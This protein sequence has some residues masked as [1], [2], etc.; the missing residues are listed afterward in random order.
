MVRGVRGV[1]R[2]SFEEEGRPMY[3]DVEKK[4]NMWEMGNMSE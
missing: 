1:M 2:K 4:V 3:A